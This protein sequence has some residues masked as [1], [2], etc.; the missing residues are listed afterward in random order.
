MASLFKFL[1]AVV[2][3]ALV[4]LADPFATASLVDADYEVIEDDPNEATEGNLVP[5]SPT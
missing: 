3:V 1:L 4:A 5:P 2:V